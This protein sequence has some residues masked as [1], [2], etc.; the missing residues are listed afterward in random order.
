MFSPWLHNETG[1]FQKSQ[2]NH[3]V[4]PSFLP[5]CLAFH[6]PICS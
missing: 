6:D 4:Y 2:Q 3:F 5:P 1:S